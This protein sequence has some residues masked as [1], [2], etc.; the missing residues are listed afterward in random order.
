MPGAQGRL[1]KINLPGRMCGND[2]NGNATNNSVVYRGR[3]FSKENAIEREA[4]DAQ[5]E[6]VKFSWQRGLRVIG[7]YLTTGKIQP[8]N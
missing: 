2:V 7:L 3:P 6:V 5:G 8:G 1:P 4:Q